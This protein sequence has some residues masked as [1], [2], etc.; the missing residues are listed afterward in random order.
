VTPPVEVVAIV[1]FWLVEEARKVKRDETDVVAVTPLI[2][3]VMTPRFAESVEELMMEVDVERPFMVDVKV[4]TAE[5]RSFPL[6]N[7]AVVVAV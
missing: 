1:R 6:M 4:F 5:A 7:R 3:V 2:K